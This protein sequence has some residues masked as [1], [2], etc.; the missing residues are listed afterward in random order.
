[1]GMKISKK[2]AKKNNKNN[3]HGTFDE[4]QKILEKMGIP[5]D[6]KFH[7]DM[8]N[9]LATNSD[10]MF[11]RKFNK[12]H[13]SLPEIYNNTS[14]YINKFYNY[15]FERFRSINPNYAYDSKTHKIRLDKPSE[16]SS[17]DSKKILDAVPK[18]P[19]EAE[20]KEI[21]ELK[22]QVGKLNKIKETADD[23]EDKKSKHENTLKELSDKL[24]ESQDEQREELNK[25]LNEKKAKKSV[26]K[27]VNENKKVEPSE[28]PKGTGIGIMEPKRKMKI[29]IKKINVNE[30]SEE[31]KKPKNENINKN[32]NKKAEPE[33]KPNIEPTFDHNKKYTDEELQNF[34]KEWQ[35]EIEG[36]KKNPSNEEIMKTFR[37]FY[38]ASYKSDNMK[39]DEFLSYLEIVVNDGRFIKEKELIKDKMYKS[40]GEKALIEDI[41]LNIFNDE[42]KNKVKFLDDEFGFF[43]DKFERYMEN[44]HPGFKIGD[45]VSDTD[46]LEN[47][48]KR[49]IKSID[50]EWNIKTTNKLNEILAKYGFEIKSITPGTGNTIVFYDFNKPYE[51]DREDREDGKIDNDPANSKTFF[52]YD[53]HEIY[54]II[55]KGLKIKLSTEAKN[56]IESI[57]RT[58]TSNLINHLN[59]SHGSSDIQNV[60]EKIEKYISSRMKDKSKPFKFTESNRYKL[61]ELLKRFL[62]TRNN[63]QK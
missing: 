14:G 33:T 17:D 23:I 62:N 45:Y 39:K 54:R 26:Q 4:S 35:E 36:K 1:M 16:E 52:S 32:E 63:G 6:Y 18:N 19:T 38:H 61:K 8:V 46:K 55:E 29:T 9:I 20:K 34:I 31:P 7:N 58:E 28:K 30:P 59:I 44:N 37:N 56:D 43:R 15:C 48:L 41:S 60:I 53:I 12:W 22:D 21:S 47:D 24:E 40:T 42:F 49:L 50:F 25:K 57:V 2:I 13:S 27:E 51:R 3:K 10:E 11:M 5:K